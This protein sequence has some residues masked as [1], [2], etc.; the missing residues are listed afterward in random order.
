MGLESGWGTIIC[1]HAYQ[2]LG[3][4][5]IVSGEQC[6]KA[7]GTSFKLPP[8]PC[9]PSHGSIPRYIV[10]TYCTVWWADVQTECTMLVYKVCIADMP[11]NAC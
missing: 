2:M 1:T 3:M 7:H 4:H 11:A 10:T 6:R 9:R 8:N 5:V